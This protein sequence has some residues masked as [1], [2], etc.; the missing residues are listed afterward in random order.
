MG[1][2]KV[3]KT[4]AVA[5]VETANNGDE[6]KAIKR[7][8]YEVVFL[9][10]GLVHV[11]ESNLMVADKSIKNKG[12]LILDV[13]SGYI[14]QIQE[15]YDIVAIISPS[16]FFV[17]QVALICEQNDLHSLSPKLAKMLLN[18]YEFRQK[19][20]SLNYLV[21]E[22]KLCTSLDEGKEWLKI[23]NKNWVFKPLN[24]NESVGVK[25]IKSPEDLAD[26]YKKLKQLSRFSN[27][28][29]GDR[30]ILE[31]YI[32]GPVYSCEFLK[33]KENILV[34][35]VTNRSMSE[36]PHFIELGYEF[37]VQDAVARNI[38]ETTLRFIQDFE[39]DFGP[40][41]I[42]YIVN[43][44]NV[45]ILE[46]NPRLVGFPNYWMIDKTLNVDV[47]KLVMELFIKGNLATVSLEPTGYSAC[48]E[49]TAPME[50]YLHSIIFEK[51]WS[52]NQNV[53]I[54]LNAEVG[55]YVRTASSNKDILVRILVSG[56]N[57]KQTNEFLQEVKSTLKLLIS[58]NENLYDCKS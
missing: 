15:E 12:I 14:K 32:S 43:E 7:L 56:E 35:G 44:G 47:L 27:H 46:V 2:D 11:D 25:L 18:K 10:T 19:Q 8:N 21:P 55:K 4:Q 31:E 48:V 9:Y 58:N 23:N 42:E 13:L 54:Y 53:F 33:D 30:Y 17:H 40:C 34:L 49:I 41:H 52:N 38:V 20:K 28:V 6:I 16:D 39:F 36:P 1:S 24:G 45:Y 51:D 50:G 3:K 57:K 37:P 29:I 22:F 5:L 26:S